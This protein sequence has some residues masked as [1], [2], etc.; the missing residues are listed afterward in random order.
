MCHNRSNNLVKGDYLDIHLNL[1][2][3][4]VRIAVAGFPHVINMAYF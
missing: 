3:G 4:L 2:S 1:I